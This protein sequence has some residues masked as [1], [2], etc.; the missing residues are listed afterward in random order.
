MSISTH[1]KCMN[2][3]DDANVEANVVEYGGDVTVVEN[4]TSGGGMEISDDEALQMA[5]ALSKSSVA[6]VEDGENKETDHATQGGVIESKLEDNNAAAVI[7][8]STITVEQEKSLE[9][10][11]KDFTQSL[12]HWYSNIEKDNAEAIEDISKM[13]T[14]WIELIRSVTD[15]T[16]N[17]E[18]VVEVGATK[19]SL[20]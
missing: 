13:D 18:S 11:G 14:S 15:A 6:V 20:N 17:N 9:I 12:P 1:A 8:T 2:Y 19:N 16:E 4:D 7:S 5:L 3:Y 10:S